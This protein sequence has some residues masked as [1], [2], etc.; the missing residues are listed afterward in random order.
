VEEVRFPGRNGVVGVAPNSTTRN[1][2]VAA[3][4]TGAVSGL[5]RAL[6]QAGAKLTSP[7]RLRVV[8][9]GQVP[10]GFRLA[11][12]EVHPKEAF[13]DQPGSIGLRYRF[14]AAERTGVRIELVRAAGKKVVRTWHKPGQLPYSEHGQNWDG[15]EGDG[16]A[17]DDGTYRFRVGAFG[18]RSHAA[19]E[20]KLRGY[21]FPVR[22]AHGYGGELQSFGAP[23]S[24]G[25]RHEGQDVY[26]S[27]GTPLVAARGG[28]VQA[29][30]F[31]PKLY[32]NFVVIDGEKTGADHMYAHMTSSSRFGDGARVHTGE[33]I[34]S[35][36]KTGNAR[37]TP[38]HLHFEIWPHG[39]RNSS[40]VD[41]KPALKRWDGWS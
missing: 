20:L 9:P 41:P 31:D 10:D 19:G 32:G 30:G 36:G 4:P 5:P 35:V 40:P 12:S 29:K 7:E 16:D 3:I 14:E 2:V 1:K 26:A 15:L 22:G 23:R 38:C 34:G 11:H 17:A 18:K 25:R 33:R 8:G 27:C 13:F 21:K 28:E 6:T 39:W 24:G 37:T